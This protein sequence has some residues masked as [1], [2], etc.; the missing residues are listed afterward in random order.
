MTWV[1]HGGAKKRMNVMEKPIKG[2]L[3]KKRK[4]ITRGWG[5]VVSIGSPIHKTWGG[6]QVPKDTRLGEETEGT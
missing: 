6:I 5:G 2:R 1:R 4:N 3:A